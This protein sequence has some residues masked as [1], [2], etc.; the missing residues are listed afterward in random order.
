MPGRCTYAASDASQ[1]AKTCPRQG[2]GRGARTERVVEKPVE[3]F[4]ERVRKIIVYVP[5]GYRFEDLDNK[6]NIE[7][8]VEAKIGP[9]GRIE[10]RQVG[11]YA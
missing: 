9:H 7:A 5:E 3:K 1:L 8:E 4:V 2:Q 11:G 6:A 10:L